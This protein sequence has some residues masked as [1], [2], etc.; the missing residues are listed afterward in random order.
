VI[1][2]RHRTEYEALFGVLPVLRDNVGEPRYAESAMPG[3][4]AWDAI[5][6]A[7][8][9]ATTRIYVNFG[10]AIAAYE[11]RIV[12]R[13]SRFDQFY[14]ELAANE[15]DS[16]IL[17]EQEKP[18]LAVFVGK[19][20]CAECHGGANFSDWKFY[21]IG[22]PQIGD[23]VAELDLGRDGGVAQVKG[24][25][26]NCQSRW[27]DQTDKDACAVATLALAESDKGAFRN[28]TLRDISNTPP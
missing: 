1:A 28:P 18:G 8:R 10:K 20:R 6:E 16:E 14:D 22:V 15:N 17:D 19:G 26:F 21:N 3:T 27:S 23:G 12:S 5:P 13:N 9:D 25:E 7:E 4:P 11:R 24:D 2:D